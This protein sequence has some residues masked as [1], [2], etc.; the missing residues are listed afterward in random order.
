MSVRPGNIFTVLERELRKTARR[1]VRGGGGSNLNLYR[2]E[3]FEPIPYNKRNKCQT[4]R[5]RDTGTART[6]GPRRRCNISRLR[7]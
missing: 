1:R 5:T 7:P 3:I 2:N 4:A 6:A